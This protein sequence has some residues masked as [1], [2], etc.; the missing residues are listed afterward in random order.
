MKLSAS[1]DA[2]TSSTLLTAYP[3]NST[4]YIF[5][6]T[7]S[8]NNTLLF[9]FKCTLVQALRLCT[10]RTAHRGSRGIA[11]LFHDHG[12]RRGWGVSVTS[13]PLFTTGKDPVPIVQEAGWAQGQSGQVRKISSP[14]EF[15]P[16]TVQPVAKHITLIKLKFET[17]Y[18]Q[19]WEADGYTCVLE[20]APWKWQSQV[21]TYKTSLIIIKILGFSPSRIIDRNAEQIRLNCFVKEVKALWN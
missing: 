12:N 13:R 19:T 2:F 10:G 1:Q 5:S 8:L 17:S 9:F 21:E 18:M 20:I 3:Y 7:A 6:S 15:D 16:R 11:L 14:P 4:S